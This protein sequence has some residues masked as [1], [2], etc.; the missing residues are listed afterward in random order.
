MVLSPGPS[1][2]LTL[3][4]ALALALS[5]TDQLYQQTSATAEHHLRGLIYLS[6]SFESRNPNVSWKPDPHVNISDQKV[7]SFVNNVIKNEYK[8]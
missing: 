7:S 2:V 6:H 1:L 8:P 3:T 4:I 5:Q